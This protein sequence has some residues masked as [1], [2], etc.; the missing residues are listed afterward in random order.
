MDPT[1]LWPHVSAVSCEASKSNGDIR[2]GRQPTAGQHAG[3]AAGRLCRVGWAHAWSRGAK[4][5]REGL[6]VRVRGFARVCLPVGMAFNRHRQDEDLD[7]NI[8]GAHIVRGL[9]CLATA[10]AAPAPRGRAARSPPPFLT[11]FALSPLWAPRAHGRAHGLQDGEHICDKFDFHLPGSSST[12][13]HTVRAASAP[14]HRLLHPPQPPPPPHAHGPAG[15]GL[16]RHR[17]AL[18]QEV[19][20]PRERARHGP[21]GAGERGAQEEEAAAASAASAGRG[22]GRRRDRGQPVRRQRL[23]GAA[24]AAGDGGGAGQCAV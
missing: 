21:R 20:A 22:V 24:H 16:E 5:N 11:H 12:P 14:G 23:R 18:L 10:H 7:G 13:D 15:L 19:Q 9:R 8:R 1:T 2:D 4:G 17:G 6:V 3:R